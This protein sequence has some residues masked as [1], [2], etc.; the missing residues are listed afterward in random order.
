MRRD[1]LREAIARRVG[2]AMLA[3]TIEDCRK[4]AVRIGRLALT[5]LGNSDRRPCT[6]TDR[7]DPER[8]DA[9]VD[10]TM[11]VVIGNPGDE[12]M[13][14]SP[15]TDAHTP[16]PGRT[17]SPTFC[18]SV[19]IAGKHKAPWEWGCLFALKDGESY[20]L[21]QIAHIVG[22]DTTTVQ[23]KLFALGCGPVVAEVGKVY[24]GTTIRDKAAMR[25]IGKHRGAPAK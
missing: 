16:G 13:N 20:T 21:E 2:E 10:A 6:A 22:V 11:T 8:T 12:V 19:K 24:D 3:D 1:E 18:P 4:A 14:E 17:R 9:P 15:V 7:D 5:A 25:S 23:T